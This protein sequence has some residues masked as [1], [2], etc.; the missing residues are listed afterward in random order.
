MTGKINHHIYLDS[1][2]YRVSKKTSIYEKVIYKKYLCT[3]KKQ[4]ISDFNPIIIGGCPRSGTTLARALIG[5]H[6]KIASPEKEYNALIFITNDNILQERLDISSK[7][8][9]NLKTNCRDHIFYAENILKYY[10]LKDKKELIAIKHPFHILILDELIHYFPK[11]KF[12]H[13][14]RD[15]RDTTCSLRTHPKRKI[16][17]GII[18]PID[19]NNPFDWCIRRWVTSINIGKKWRTNANYTEIKYEDLIHKT[20]GTLKKIF[21]FIGINMVSKEKI[22]NFY[23]NQNDKNHLQNIEVGQPIY[24]K[25]IGRWKKDMN[26][27]EILLFKK[28]AGEHLIELNYERDY[29]W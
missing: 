22:Y 9:T 21:D 13:I 24:K 8:I 26:E 7:E 23:K 20:E 18:T 2:I 28:M 1:L 17:D 11:M 14:I 15:G 29:N 6:P 12:I 25:T 10:M 3:K 5:V 16:A 4:Y 27:K 19:T